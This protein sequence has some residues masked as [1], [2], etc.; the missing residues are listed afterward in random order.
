MV[1]RP[2]IF[3][4]FVGKPVFMAGFFYTKK[5]S[6][7]FPCMV[8]FAQKNERLTILEN[9]LP[10]YFKMTICIFSLLFTG[11]PFLF[12]IRISHVILS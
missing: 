9:C 8:P 2:S 12:S 6:P 4:I 1:K 10:S 5:D 11:D 3:A 7:V